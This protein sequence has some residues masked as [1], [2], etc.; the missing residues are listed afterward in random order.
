MSKEKEIGVIIK[1]KVQMVMFRDFAK[2]EAGAL[3]IVGTAENL[4]DGSA[5]VVA[6]GDEGKLK[7]FIEKL[8]IGPQYAE[9][10][11][12]NV[13]WMEIGKKFNDFKIIWA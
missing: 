6:Q 3:G 11:S 13:E 1:G 4:S 10:E 12:A 2:R 5:R 8:K 7:E 9:V